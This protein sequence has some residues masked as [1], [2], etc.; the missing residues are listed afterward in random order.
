ME[1]QEDG[2]GATRQEMLSEAKGPGSSVSVVA[3]KHGV[4]PSQP[5]RWRQLKE[6]GSVSG[7]KAGEAVV[8]ESEM[9]TLKA[10]VRELQR[11]LGK[12]T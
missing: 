11:L 8:P 6:A 3:C 7:L 10:R 9:Q 5:F 2:D 1:S 4:N 12:K